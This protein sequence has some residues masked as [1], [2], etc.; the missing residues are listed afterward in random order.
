MF[1]RWRLEACLG[2]RSCWA[3]MA[4]GHCSCPSAVCPQPS[5]GTHYINRQPAACLHL[6]PQQDTL[7][8][9]Q[10][11]SHQR[12]CGNWTH[13]LSLPFCQVPLSVAMHSMIIKKKKGKSPAGVA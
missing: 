13:S 7:V 11:G 12:T 8:N 2:V 4:S 6:T 9:P 5:R 3:R 1:L 10:Q